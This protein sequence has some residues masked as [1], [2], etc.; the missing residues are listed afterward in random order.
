MDVHH[1]LD[2]P[3]NPETFLPR[4]RAHYRFGGSLTTP[5]CLEGVRWFVLAQP[6]T[7]SDE[8]LARFVGLVGFDARPVQR[9]FP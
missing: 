4:N 2:A 1:E 7:V 3:F 6:V 9:R 8:H 5:P